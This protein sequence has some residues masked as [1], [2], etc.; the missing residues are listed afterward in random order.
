ME[1]KR[2]LLQPPSHNTSTHVIKSPKENLF[3]KFKANYDDLNLL[4][5]PTDAS[6][7]E[8]KFVDV[9]TTVDDNNGDI[10]IKTEVKYIIFYDM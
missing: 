4:S 7:G 3:N 6:T 5:S 1:T 10:L 8:T 2:A 9:L